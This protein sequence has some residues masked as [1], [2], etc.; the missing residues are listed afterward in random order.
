MSKERIKKLG[1]K[2][3]DIR[4][5]KQVSLRDLAKLTDLTR[6]FLSQVERG[7]S[8]P[9]ITSLEKIASALN[10]ELSYFFKEDFP[11]KFSLFRKKRKKIFLQK[12]TK[13]SC[14][15]LVSDLLDIAMVPLLFTL[16]KGA[17]IGEERLWHY[18]K[19]K[20]MLTQEGKVEI[21]C[22]KKDKKKFVLEEGDS[23][24]CKCECPCKKMENIGNKKAV[25]LWVMRAP[26]L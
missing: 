18:K 6:S 3:K 12:D 10:T 1:S 17:K 15:V 11:Q 20:F 13:I 23:L 14:E 26:L 24:Y 9:S 16:N 2:I 4:L 8:S 21:T 19:E 25:I 7:I 22:S 5:S